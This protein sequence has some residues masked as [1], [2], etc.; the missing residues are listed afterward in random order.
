MSTGRSFAMGASDGTQKSQD[1]AA[2]PGTEARPSTSPPLL[3]WINC[4]KCKASFLSIKGEV[5]C[6]ACLPE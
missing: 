5:L 6:W 4:Q 1:L 2:A 3:W